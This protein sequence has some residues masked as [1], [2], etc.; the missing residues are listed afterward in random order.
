ME[1]EDQA[2]FLSPY[3]TAYFNR[4]DNALGFAQP[5]FMTRESISYYLYWQR[6]TQKLNTETIRTK[7]IK[8][9]R[10][11]ARKLHKQARTLQGEEL[12]KVGAQIEVLYKLAE[13]LNG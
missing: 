7:V 4:R 11:Q 12:R 5:S 6:E 13:K 2:L 9:I 3:L 8:D 10:R 1:K